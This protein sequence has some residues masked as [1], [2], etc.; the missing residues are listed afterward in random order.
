[1]RVKKK[2]GISSRYSF[3]SPIFTTKIG[4][5][6][7]SDGPE[8]HRSEIKDFDITGKLLSENPLR[9]FMIPVKKN[10]PFDKSVEI[11]DC[12]IFENM[13]VIRQ[14]DTVALDRGTH[15]EI[16]KY[17]TEIDDAKKVAGV[18][19]HVIKNISGKRNI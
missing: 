15:Y 17:E 18:L 9:F 11:G 5:K 8:N 13:T 16:K 4:N 14:N 19:R 6:E 7:G 1:M 2:F 3:E 10:Y 12:L